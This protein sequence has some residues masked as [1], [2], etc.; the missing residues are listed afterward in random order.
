[1]VTARVIE[2]VKGLDMDVAKAFASAVHA[3]TQLLEEAYRNQDWDKRRKDF[4]IVEQLARK[5]TSILSFI[6]EYLLHPRHGSQVRRLER[7]DVVTLITIHSAKGTE[8]KVCYV[9]NGS[10]ART[11][12]NTPST[13][14]T[15]VRKSGGSCTWQ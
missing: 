15:R 5:H 2:N 4:R 14:R 12:R 10:P 9:A 1:M 13:M 8:S 6:E 7:D 3:L 11:P